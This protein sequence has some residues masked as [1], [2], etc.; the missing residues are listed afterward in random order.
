[1][2]NYQQQSPPMPPSMLDARRWEHT[3]LRRRLLEGTW[4]QDL[5]ERLELHLGSVRR[6]AWGVPDLSSNPFRIICRELSALYMAAPDVRHTRS[7]ERAE[8]LVGGNGLIARLGLWAT[9]QR[10]Q[11]LVIGLP[12]CTWSLLLQ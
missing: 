9:M 5:I 3:R 7:P 10:F 4:E 2:T 6:Q 8:A 12:P 11:S 1:M